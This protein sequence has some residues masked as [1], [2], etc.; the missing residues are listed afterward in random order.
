MTADAYAEDV[1]KC[2]AAGMNAHIAKPIDPAVL[3]QT[4]SKAVQHE[5]AVVLYTD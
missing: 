2:L 1:Q 4:L 5:Q 3:Y